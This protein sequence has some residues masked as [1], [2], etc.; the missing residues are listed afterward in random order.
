VTGGNGNRPRLAVYWLSACGGCQA[1]FLDLGEGLASLADRF[2]I[3]LFPLLMDGKE[4]DLDRF[5]PGEIDLCLLSGCVRNAHDVSLA[6]RFRERAV[7]LVALGSCAHTGG[8]PGLAGT[9]TADELLEAAYGSARPAPRT[10]TPRGNTLT[11]PPLEP[12]VRPLDHVVPVDFIIPGCPPEPQT[13]SKAL[14]LLEGNGE[15]LRAAPE[16]TVLGA[17][18]LCLCEECPRN[19]PSGPLESLRRPHG[20]DPDPE[21]CLLDQ[22]VLCL[23][24]ATRA[25]CGALC[26]AMGIGCRGCYGPLDGILDQGGRMLG[27]LVALGSPQS[28]DER[29]ASDQA[30]KLAN[31]VQDPVGSLYRFSFA[32]SLLGRFGS[33]EGEE[34]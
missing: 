13:L 23:G 5:G 34:P 22:G 3:V 33:G 8:V 2:E 12:V 9:C 29:E 32:A 24:P 16:G 18:S 10:T 17:G 1:A 19:P 26:P 6:R 31:S 11:L 27:A 25:G 14:A 15:T 20:A 7:V 21:R 28:F 30:L 4:A